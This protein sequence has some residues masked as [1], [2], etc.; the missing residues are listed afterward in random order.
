MERL[1]AL[2]VFS[3][4]RPR[5]LQL[6]LMQ[7]D[8]FSGTAYLEPALASLPR[9]QCPSIAVIPAIRTVV[10]DCVGTWTKM[11]GVTEQDVHW[12]SMGTRHGEK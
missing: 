2:L 9:P 6:Y 1:E 7:S 8:R 11:L 5:Q 10:P 3:L 12:D 4:R